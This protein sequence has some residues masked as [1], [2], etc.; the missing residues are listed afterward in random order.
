MFNNTETIMKKLL[1]ILLFAIPL[2]SNAQEKIITFRT[3][4]MTES[5]WSTYSDQWISADEKP[6]S[7]VGILD[8]EKGYFKWADKDEK[9]LIISSEETLQEDR[10]SILYKTTLLGD[11][12]DIIF[13]DFNDEE[14]WDYFTFI[15]DGVALLFRIEIIK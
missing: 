15:E 7:W 14:D 13:A 11:N 3:H 4:S 10:R 5:V 1:I 8:L 6:M 9:C 2:L 12:V